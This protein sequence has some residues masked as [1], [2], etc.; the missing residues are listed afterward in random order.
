MQLQASRQTENSHGERELSCCLKIGSPKSQSPVEVV[1]LTG[2][3]NN[4]T[5]SLNIR[6]MLE[7]EQFIQTMQDMM[8]SI[9]AST[10]YDSNKSMNSINKTTTNATITHLCI[11]P[12]HRTES[13]FQKPDVSTSTLTELASSVQQHVVWEKPIH[14]H[15]EHVDTGGYVNSLHLVIFPLKNRHNL[16]QEVHGSLAA[17]PSVRRVVLPPDNYST[18]SRCHAIQLSLRVTEQ[19]LKVH[20]SEIDQF[21]TCKY[22]LQQNS[23]SS[24]FVRDIDLSEDS[25]YNITEDYQLVACWLELAKSVMK[26]QEDTLC[27]GESVPPVGNTDNINL[28]VEKQVFG[29]PEP[30]KNQPRKEEKDTTE[31]TRETSISKKT[32]TVTAF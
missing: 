32:A 3:F 1:D 24:Q 25:D 26:E 30:Q 12:V 11:S 18:P 29:E 21:R 27:H 6:Q 16:P 10:A 14:S 22:S 7:N 15:L 13:A 19:T 4:K 28:G 31:S 23:D 5:R 2:D 17:S 9:E 8:G 20:A